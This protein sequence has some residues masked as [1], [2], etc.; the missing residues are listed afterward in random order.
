MNTGENKGDKHIASL[1]ERA[2]TALRRNRNAL[3]FDGR[4]CFILFVLGQVIHMAAYTNYYLGHDMSVFHNESFGWDLMTGRFLGWLPKSL[5]GHLQT[6]WLIG[7]ISSLFMA[8]TAIGI[9]KTFKVRSLLPAL[10]IGLVNITW[11]PWIAAHGYLYMLTQF[12]FSFLTA[13]WA[14]YFLDKKRGFLVAGVLLIMSLACYQ[15]CAGI[16]AGLVLLSVILR[17]SR[18]EENRKTLIYGLKGAGTVIAGVALYYLLWQLLLKKYGLS[19]AEYRDMNASFGKQITAMALSIPSVYRHIFNW[20]TGIYS[21]SY[22]STVIKWFI[23]LPSAAG[24]ALAIRHAVKSGSA[25]DT[26]ALPDTGKGEGKTAR[27]ILILLSALLMPFAM[28]VSQF[29]NPGQY[30]SPTME[31]AYILPVLC[32]IIAFISGAPG[33]RVSDGTE[34][35]ACPRFYKA[36]SVLTF[37]MCAAVIINGV[38]GANASY[39]QQRKNSYR[40]DAELSQIIVRLSQEENYTLDTPVAVIA[41]EDP[42]ADNGGFEWCRDL[43]GISDTTLTYEQAMYNQLRQMAPG[44]CLV[45]ADPFLENEAVTAL[46]PYPAHDCLTHVGDTIVIR[47]RK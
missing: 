23:L 20:Y 9:L 1:R 29:F 33:K 28:N 15:S 19:A 18:G 6:P 25:S 47:I 14:V 11:P 26:A 41:D 3:L 30:V 39:L 45:S 40:C 10:L 4:V 8:L 2:L 12:S 17:A 31:C 43:T 46:S 21:T 13:V 5:H 37:L 7:C 22:F 42:N 36:M 34:V 27:V 32:L 16:T 24:I 44:I 38:Y 35:S